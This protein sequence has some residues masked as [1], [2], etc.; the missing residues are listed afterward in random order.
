MILNLGIVWLLT[1]IWHGDTIGFLIWG[2][3]YF[4]LIV[5]EKV[6]GCPAKF[7]SR[8]LKVIYRIFSL[9]MINFLWVEFYFGHIADALD[10]MKYMLIPSEYNISID[11][12]YFLLNSYKVFIA[13]AI[14]FAGP[15]VPAIMKLSQKKRTI[16]I[17]SNVIYGFGVTGLF[18]LSIAV[19]VG[20]ESNP[21]LYIGF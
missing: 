4:L 13:A 17:I 10:F 16:N 8:S 14:I 2:T 21:F 3:A 11:R 20:G 15:I 5:F 7:K 6:S 12:A 19:I 1:G 9:L 18:I